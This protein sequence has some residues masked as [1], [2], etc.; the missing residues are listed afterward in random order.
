L[1]HD[2]ACLWPNDLITYDKRSDCVV[3]DTDHLDM[4]HDASD[5]RE[6]DDFDNSQTTYSENDESE[7]QDLDH[8]HSESDDDTKTATDINATIGTRLFQ[9]YN[10]H[11][12]KPNAMSAR[13][14]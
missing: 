11:K 9:S 3:L 12:H 2:F 14:F 5:S 10:F 13:H 1:T 8:R 7:E 4:E 6:S